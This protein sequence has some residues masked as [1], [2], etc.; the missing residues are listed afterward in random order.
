MCG[1]AGM[2]VSPRPRT[3]AQRY[4]LVRATGKLLIASEARGIDAAGIAGI[5]PDWYA[6]A[7]RSGLASQL[8]ADGALLR[9]SREFRAGISVLLG[10]TRWATRGSSENRFNLHPFRCGPVVG[11]HNGTVHNADELFD[12]HRFPRMG[13]TDSELLFRMAERSVDRTG[14]IQTACWRWWLSLC[15][16]SLS[17]VAVSRGDPERVVVVRGNKPLVLRV[18]EDLGAVAYASEARF[19]RSALSP[20]D[21][22]RAV[23]L[24]AMSMA[25]FD[26]SG[27]V[28]PVELEAVR[29]RREIPQRRV[30]P[31]RV[32]S[33]LAPASERARR[34]SK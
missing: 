6:L 31:S 9:V 12:A 5:G 3:D 29:F 23:R 32:F 11:T 33:G 26:V 7:K 15:R 27:G 19:L 4:E 1:L 28:V 17:A 10:H 34:R 20:R 8:V 25:V 18:S 24:P 16:G 13:E 30:S 21:N 22:W 2:M 14:R